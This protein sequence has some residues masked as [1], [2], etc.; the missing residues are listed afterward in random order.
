M[1]KMHSNVSHFSPVIP[2]MQFVI[3]GLKADL[4]LSNLRNMPFGCALMV[5]GEEEA[6]GQFITVLHNYLTVKSS[7]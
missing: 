2:H 1:R 3:S 7:F 4:S 6:G 5:K